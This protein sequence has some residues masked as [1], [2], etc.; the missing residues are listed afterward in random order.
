[1]ERDV[2]GTKPLLFV[3]KTAFNGNQVMSQR[4]FRLQALDETLLPRPCR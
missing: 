2:G 4:A 3:K 1:M